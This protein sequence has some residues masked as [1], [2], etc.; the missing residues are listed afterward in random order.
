M[1]DGL[2]PI[3]GYEGVYWIDIKYGVVFNKDRH[4][5]KSVRTSKGRVVELRKNGQR[6]KL[7]VQDL[8]SRVQ[9]GK[10]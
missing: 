5:M 2:Y 8:I 7:L 1:T 10:A 4:C 3:P 6:E 9:E